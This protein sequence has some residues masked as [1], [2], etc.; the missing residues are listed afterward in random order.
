MTPREICVSVKFTK[1][2]GNYQSFV[3]EAGVTASL[4]NPNETPAQAFDTAWAMVRE[5]VVNQIKIASQKAG[6]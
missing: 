1:N 6:E 2:M 5:Q 4:D 3:A